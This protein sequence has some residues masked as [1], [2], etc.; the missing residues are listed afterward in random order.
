VNCFDDELPHS[1]CEAE[2]V[3]VLSLNGLRSSEGCT[4]RTVLPLSGVALFNT[5]DGTVPPCL[6]NLRNLTVVHLVGNGFSGELIPK[7]PEFSQLFDI[8]LSHNRLSGKIPLDFLKV[9][10]LDLSF[11]QFE[12][13][14]A[15]RSQEILDTDINLE[16]NRLS[17]QLPVSGLQRLSNSS[18]RVLRGNMFSCNT[19][20]DTDE[21]SHDYVCGS[22]HLNYSLFSF[23]MALSVVLAMLLMALSMSCQGKGSTVYEMGTRL[24]TAA[25]FLLKVDVCYWPHTVSNAIY[26]IMML[27]GTF[28][29]IMKCAVNLLIVV[30]VG[31]SSLYIV[32]L[33][34]TSGDFAT[35]SHTYSWFWTL[36]YMRGVVPAGL[37]ILVWV[38]AISACFYRVV[39]FDAQ[40]PVSK[41]SNSSVCKD[42]RRIIATGLV[43][44]P[45]FISTDLVPICVAFVFNGGVTIIVNTLYIFSTQQDLGPS[46]HFVLQLS[47][48][49]FRL[50]YT[51]ILLPMLTRSMRSPVA[52]VRFRSI[53]LTI[54][55]LLIPCFVTALTSDACF[56]VTINSNSLTLLEFQ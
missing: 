41:D 9:A 48:S 7:L 20:P 21:Y 4:A 37:L 18:L 31:S 54:N 15:Y 35:H 30:L 17:G 24:W 23:M 51:V 1:I 12:G 36:A 39:V 28:L 56:Q 55:S 42:S 14:Y 52:I 53:V 32:K 16:I 29:E 25:T 13:E 8:S 11:N 3:E 5:I 45:A 6:W 27:S 26:K 40:V 43:D 49:I 50:A 33:L 2:K 44:A 10:K 19:I 34:D 47:L 38:G 46:V 22:L